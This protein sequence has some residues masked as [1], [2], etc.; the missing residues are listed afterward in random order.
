MGRRRLRGMSRAFARWIGIN[1]SLWLTVWFVGGWNLKLIQ[2][3]IVSFQTLVPS[4]TYWDLTFPVEMLVGF[5]T[6][7]LF[8]RP[9]ALRHA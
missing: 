1:F 7:W 2:A 4:F 6:F 8:L 3:I 5:G 9:S